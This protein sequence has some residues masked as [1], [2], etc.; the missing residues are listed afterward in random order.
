M[1]Y[2][3]DTRPFLWWCSQS[4]KLSP[5]VFKLIKRADS[6]VYVSLVSIRETQ[7]K[8]QLGK[9]DLPAPMMDILSY[10]NTENNIKLLA[11]ELPHMQALTTL[12]NLHLDPF[13]RIIVAQAISENMTI[14]TQ[15]RNIAKYRV[16]VLW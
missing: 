15:D 8:S 7:I 14:I 10:Q 9:V 12:P 6:S 3:L 13:D 4:A 5:E 16:K 2:L 1:K 11:I